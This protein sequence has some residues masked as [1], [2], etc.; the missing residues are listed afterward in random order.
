M[1]L[2]DFEMNLQEAG[3]AARVVHTGSSQP[4]GTRMT[5]GGEVHLESGLLQAAP[6]LKERG[7]EIVTGS[8]IFGGYQAILRDPKTGVYHGASESRKDGHAAGW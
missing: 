1:N 6:A 4:T 8:G 3:D 2:L 7:H 5:D